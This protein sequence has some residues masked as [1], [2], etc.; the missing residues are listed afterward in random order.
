MKLATA[1]SERA[2]LQRRLSEIGTRLNNNSKVQEGEEPSESPQELMAELDRT[3]ERLEELM[4]CINLTNSKTFH[5]GKTITELLAHRDCL[6]TR[7]QVM[8]NFLDNASN[9]VNRMTRSEI[10]IKSTVPVSE[11]QKRVDLLSKEL[12]QCDEQIQEL[13]W[14]TELQG[15]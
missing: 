9:K 6:K 2:D 7:I 15:L 12:R 13:N 8:R 1:L 10:R 3:V 4:A 5:E 11:I 14:T